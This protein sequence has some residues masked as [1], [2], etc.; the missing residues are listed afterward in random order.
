MNWKAIR[1]GREDE[2]GKEG[3]FGRG[4]R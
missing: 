1:K 3:D 4:G 2:R